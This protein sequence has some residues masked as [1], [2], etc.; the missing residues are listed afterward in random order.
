MVQNESS[1]SGDE[2][3]QMPVNASKGVPEGNY[4]LV[5]WGIDTTGR[6]LI[7]EICQIAAYTPQKQFSQYIMPFSDLNF[8]FRRKHNMRVVNTG[9]YRMLKDLRSNKFV[10]TKSDITALIDFLKW[11][12]E[13]KGE[14]S[15]G[16]I[17]VYHEIRKSAPGMLLEVLRRYNLLERFG[18]TVKGFAN[19]F[20][21][22]EEKCAKTT[23]TFTLRVMS[24]VLLNR[25]DEDFSS[26]V[27]RARACYQ[28]VAHLAQ[29]ER[30]EIDEKK[31][32]IGTEPEITNF[33]A[34]FTNPITAEEEEIAEFKVSYFHHILNND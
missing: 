4:R 6:R 13:V 19:G 21:I 16:I 23:K 20:N 7:D 14:A 8:A 12:E 30:Q 17:L 24:K 5:G 26:A 1:N 28:I 22:A 29:G 31:E 32:S 9:R 33:V 11:L 27:E 15:D 2:T 3:V 25:D 10:K 18:N 34:P